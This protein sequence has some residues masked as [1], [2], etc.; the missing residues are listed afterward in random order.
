V[1]GV[2]N[3]LLYLFCREAHD[4]SGMGP[5]RDAVLCGLDWAVG[6]PVAQGV[7]PRLE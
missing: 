7:F 2:P 5:Y 4:T 6:R 1:P 3:L